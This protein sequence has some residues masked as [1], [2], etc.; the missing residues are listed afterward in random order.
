MTLRSREEIRDV[1]FDALGV[2]APEIDPAMIAPERP[3]RE[4]IDIDSFDF[5]NFI[6]RLHETLG[7]DIPEKD[8]AELLTLNSSVEYLA[9]RC[10]THQ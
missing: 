6:I 10:A 9:R 8:Y 5:L 1:I 2:I 7:I 4:Q 3:L